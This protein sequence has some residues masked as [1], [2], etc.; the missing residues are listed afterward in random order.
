MIATFKILTG[1]VKIPKLLLLELD[2]GTYLYDIRRGYFKGK[3]RVNIE[4]L[5]LTFVKTRNLNSI[6]VMVVAILQPKPIK[7][8]YAACCAAF[9]YE[10][11]TGGKE[12]T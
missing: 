11:G 2:I 4:K 12:K 3:Q 10:K 5:P 1:W 7:V 6:C 8:F 9:C